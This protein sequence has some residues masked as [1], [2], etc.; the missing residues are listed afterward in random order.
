MIFG[1]TPIIIS[2][3]HI[4][5]EIL[6]YMS[7]AYFISFGVLHIFVYSKNIY[8]YIYI[9]ICI[10]IYIYRPFHLEYWKKED[11]ITKLSKV[12]ESDDKTKD[13]ELI[14]TYGGVRVK[15]TTKEEKEIEKF[16]FTNVM[17]RI[18]FISFYS[19]LCISPHFSFIASFYPWF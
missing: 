17:F 18:H 8:I 5:I 15:S 9:Y 4:Y 3:N 7:F 6:C 19:P 14:Q 16:L 10:Y 12:T 1:K 2:Q 13:F 11:N